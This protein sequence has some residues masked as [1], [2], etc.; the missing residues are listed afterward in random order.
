MAIMHNK[1]HCK[2][3]QI[4]AVLRGD[5][6]AIDN[7]NRLSNFLADSFPEPFPDTGMDLLRLEK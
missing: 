3:T 4:A 6:A 1:K 2:L 5:A 7:A